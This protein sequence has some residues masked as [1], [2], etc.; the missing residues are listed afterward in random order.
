MRRVIENNRLRCIRLARQVCYAVRTLVGLFRSDRRRFVVDVVL[1]VRS[2][3]I[4]GAM[5]GLAGFLRTRSAGQ[6]GVAR[7][8]DQNRR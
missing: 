5:T 8:N 7:G 1:N 6:R 3:A 4:I 2:F